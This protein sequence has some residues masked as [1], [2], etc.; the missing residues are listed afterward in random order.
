MSREAK[1]KEEI[2]KLIDLQRRRYSCVQGQ[3]WCA[4]WYAAALC[5]IAAEIS[6]KHYCGFN[7]AIGVA[8]F[9]QSGAML[10]ILGGVKGIAAQLHDLSSK[11]T[12]IA[13]ELL[14]MNDFKKI[15]EFIEFRR[16]IGAVLANELGIDASL[17]TDPDADYLNWL[18]K[19]SW[20]HRVI[21]LK[22]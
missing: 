14:L 1:M 16:N 20:I 10:F 7:V 13:E 6:Q 2:K 12:K 9:I 4:D 22:E 3:S 15:N 8:R 21:E 17:I 19:T 11:L 18:R 5:E